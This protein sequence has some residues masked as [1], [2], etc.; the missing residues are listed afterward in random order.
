MGRATIF[1]SEQVCHVCIEG[2][3]ER[4]VV[5][6]GPTTI[7]ELKFLMYSLQTKTCEDVVDKIW[8]AKK[9]E[10]GELTVPK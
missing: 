6:V 9:Q 5:G 1:Y 4:V 10:F 2:T 8:V 7:R 3:R